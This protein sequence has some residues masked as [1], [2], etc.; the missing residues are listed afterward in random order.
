MAWAWPS[1]RSDFSRRCRS[2]TSEKWKNKSKSKSYWNWIRFLG[3]VIPSLHPT[4]RWTRVISSRSS[5]VSLV[6]SLGCGSHLPSKRER[7]A[8][9]DPSVWPYAI[10]KKII[11]KLDTWKYRKNP[12]LVSG[13]Y[14][15][16]NANNI[17]R[18]IKRGLWKLIR[19]KFDF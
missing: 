15:F 4:W 3:H 6:K 11:G 7:T 8:V 1:W 18:T 5:L 2:Q 13:I 16:S 19:F 9:N 12:L 17:K 14:H 10:F